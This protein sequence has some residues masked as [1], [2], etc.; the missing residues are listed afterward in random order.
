MGRES[1]GEGGALRF[2]QLPYLHYLVWLWC[3]LPTLCASLRSA[4]F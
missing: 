1:Y 2:A 4:S 3:Y